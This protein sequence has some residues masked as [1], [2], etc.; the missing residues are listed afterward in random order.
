MLQQRRFQSHLAVFCCNND[1]HD[2]SDPGSWPVGPLRHSHE[3]RAHHLGI[4]QILTPAWLHHNFLSTKKSKFFWIWKGR[5][6][7]RTHKKI[8]NTA[9]FVVFQWRHAPR[10]SIHVARRCFLYSC[11]SARDQTHCGDKHPPPQPRSRHNR[12]SVTQKN[13]NLTLGSFVS[14][15]SV[16]FLLAALRPWDSSGVMER[17]LYQ[18]VLNAPGLHYCDTVRCVKIACAWTRYDYGE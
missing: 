12:G 15:S 5:N 7:P 6:E 13:P 8:V 16:H 11:A 14:R 18:T 9:V 3:P 10:L 4:V 1:G 17:M 2:F